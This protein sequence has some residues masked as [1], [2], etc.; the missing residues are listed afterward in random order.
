MIWINFG[1]AG[2]SAESALDIPIRLIEN[3]TQCALPF[4]IHSNAIAATASGPFEASMEHK[5]RCMPMRTKKFGRSAQ[6][7]GDRKHGCGGMP[8]AINHAPVA[9]VTAANTTTAK[10]LT[11]SELYTS[12]MESEVR[13]NIS[14]FYIRSCLPLTKQKVMSG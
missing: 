4:F 7:G 13:I 1:S 10:Y 5:V 9:Q 6:H 12:L 8:V 11:K 2:G 14:M 3:R